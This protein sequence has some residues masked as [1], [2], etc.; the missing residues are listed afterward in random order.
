MVGVASCPALLL[1]RPD[2]EA[3][4]FRMAESPRVGRS[5]RLVLRPSAAAGAVDGDRTPRCSRSLGPGAGSFE[6]AAAR[7]ADAQ[8]LVMACGNRRHDLR[9]SAHHGRA[10]P[11]GSAAPTFASSAGAIRATASRR[12]AL[13]LTRLRAPGP[14]RALLRR[15]LL[16]LH[17]APA[18]GATSATNR[19]QSSRAQRLAVPAARA[20]A[21]RCRLRCW[22]RARQL[23]ALERRAGSARRPPQAFRSPSDRGGARPLGCEGRGSRSGH[24]GRPRAAWGGEPC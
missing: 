15:A 5:R 4:P 24:A 3:G 23:G 6:V 12:D 1:A 13:V 21:P 14:A 8:A 7:G 18:R 17:V 20:R 9:R 22:A 2:H 16:P 11:G 19:A 10:L